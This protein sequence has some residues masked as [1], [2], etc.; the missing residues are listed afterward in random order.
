MSE[1]WSQDL[2]F[3]GMII[4][5]TVL[6]I[7]FTVP[8]VRE[9][10]ARKKEIREMVVY[11][12]VTVAVVIG[13]WL[14]ITRTSLWQ[15]L[16]A[17]I[18][19]GVDGQHTETDYTADSDIKEMIPAIVLVGVIIFVGLHG[20][21]IVVLLERRK[22]EN[23]IAKVDPGYGTSGIRRK[24]ELRGMVL[25]AVSGFVLGAVIG[26]AGNYFTQD[27]LGQS[28]VAE[29]SGKPMQTVTVY[30]ADGDI[31]AQYTRNI[32]IERGWNERVTLY[33]DGEEYTYYNCSVES[34][35]AL[36]EPNNKE[37]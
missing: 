16:V 34:V 37:E 33:L 2:F 10:E 36:P 22:L 1:L 24:N 29:I 35:P 6:F 14:F 20:A 12:I 13:S 5:I 4:F 23:Q 11:W 9:G 27:P 30:A 26:W 8:L 7:I 31:I 28:F 3:A 19:S 15:A 17:E 21:L 18:D 25:A 32:T